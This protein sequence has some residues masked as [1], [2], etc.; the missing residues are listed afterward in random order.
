MN[1]KTPL[2]EQLAEKIRHE[3]EQGLYRQTGRLPPMREWARTLGVSINTLRAALVLI[4]QAGYLSVRHG[5]RMELRNAERPP[6]IG[7]FCENDL[8]DRRLSAYFSELTREL[9]RLLREQGALPRLYIGTGRPLK[10]A[11]GTA[12]WDLL[13][14]VE[15]AHLDGLA[16]IGLPRRPLCDLLARKPIPVVG[17][18]H[19]FNCGVSVD[20][21][22]LLREGCRRLHAQGARRI[23]VMGWIDPGLL[24]LLEPILNEL[25]IE[26]RSKWVTHEFEPIRPGAAWSLFREIWTAYPDKPD[27]LLVCDDV[28]FSAVV[29]TLLELNI[30]VPEQ[31]RIVS[32]ANKG[33]HPASPFPVTFAEVDPQDMARRM[34]DML[35]KLVRHARPDTVRDFSPVSWIPAPIDTGRGSTTAE[36][37]ATGLNEPKRGNMQ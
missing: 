34:A 1:R 16:I 4:E 3:I 30:H 25:G 6:R 23:A 21:A 37:I 20:W 31:L 28:L 24:G 15:A 11:A 27:G 32:H 14:D 10:H 18:S 35:L 8:L 2:H 26:F 9:R 13:H 29:P 22:G 5:S 17:D 33:A 7:I 12:D 36:R 19:F